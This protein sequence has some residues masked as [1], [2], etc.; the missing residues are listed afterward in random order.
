MVFSGMFSRDMTKSLAIMLLLGLGGC[1]DVL[2]EQGRWGQKRQ[3]QSQ[4]QSQPAAKPV[5]A[6]NKTV[7]IANPDYEPPNQ[8]LTLPSNVAANAANPG[9][10]EPIAATPI[11]PPASADTATPPSPPRNLSGNPPD[12]NSAA[13]VAENGDNAN[14]ANA[15]TP[16]T[17]AATA[18][19][20]AATAT[21]TANKP[22]DMA[23]NANPLPDAKTKDKSELVDVYIVELGDTLYAVGRKFGLPVIAIINANKLRKPYALTPGQKLSIP[24]PGLYRVVTG[25]S[26][27]GIARR[28]NLSV[29]QLAE[30]NNLK[31]PYT[32]VPGQTILLPHGSGAA[33]LPPIGSQAG[34][35]QAGG[36][37]AV[38]PPP[39]VA[40]TPSPTPAAN[41]GL[42][43]AKESGT[44]SPAPTASIPPA[45]SAPSDKDNT[46]KNPGD[47]NAGAD[48]AGI[49]GELPP[50]PPRGG[51]NFLWPLR[52]RVVSSFGEQAQGLANDGINI[53]A[54][55]GKKIVAS[56]NGVVAYAANGVRGYGNLILIKHEKGYFTA[57][58][59][60]SKS[61]V[62]RG[63]IVHRGQEIGEVGMTGAVVSPQ[64]HFEIR[65]HGKAINPVL[66]LAAP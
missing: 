17:P 8:P 41:A 64:L 15:A 31:P 1:G 4:S 54:Q 10:K 28:F 18:P 25:D 26:F 65:L 19:A 47:K 49:L 11:A 53:A 59:H 37:Q 35:G 34:G 60:L 5:T 9:Q 50:P 12:P 45:P 32:I 48:N 61:L 39:A 51:K 14:V 33:S 57:Y 22:S 16:A 6:S 42:P 62:S 29:P 44:K 20:P 52:G 66:L 24:H 43:A 36:G 46:D 7:V 3:S 21:A 56:E 30:L 27:Y 55:A 2:S 23:G 13:A 63:Q 38:T 40:P 58:A